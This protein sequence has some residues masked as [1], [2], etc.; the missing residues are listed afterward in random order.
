VSASSDPEIVAAELG[1]ALGTP[2]AVMPVSDLHEIVQTLQDC[3]PP[4][5]VDGGVRLTRGV[6]FLIG[7]ARDGLPTSTDRASYMLR[8]P[9]AVLLCKH[10][11]ETPS[12]ILD[13]NRR[14]GGWG[15]VAA[16]LG[17]NLGGTW[18][19]RSIRTLAGTLKAADAA[20]HATPTGR[21]LRR[22]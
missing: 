6:A 10:D 22:S 1:D 17:R 13:R 14:K 12:G 20:M 19:A 5:K 3:H 7:T 16:D 11:I 21:H 15:A 2:S 9:K 4:R 8:R 18:T